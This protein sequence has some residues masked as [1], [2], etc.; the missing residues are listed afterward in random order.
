MIL[1]LILNLNLNL[2][3]EL[4]WSRTHEASFSSVEKHVMEETN[5]APWVALYPVLEPL[6]SVDPS[7]GE[8]PFRRLVWRKSLQ[9][10]FF[11]ADGSSA[12]PAAEVDQD[13]DAGIEL[14]F[15]LS[16]ELYSE[17]VTLVLRAAS[18]GYMNHYAAPAH[19]QVRVLRTLM[20]S[21][22]DFCSWAAEAV[23]YLKEAGCYAGVANVKRSSDEGGPSKRSSDEGGPSSASKRR[24]RSVYE[25][26]QEFDMFAEDGKGPVGAGKLDL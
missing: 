4:D 11:L 18:S 19:V 7:C 8:P 12:I 26:V 16:K 22:P 14:M 10:D 25:G 3:L 9:G 24:A 13:D 6:P 21:P 15:P 23:E 20:D 5:D 2:K 1:N 17:E